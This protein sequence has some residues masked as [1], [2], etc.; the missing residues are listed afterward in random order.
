MCCFFASL[1]LLGPRLI[2]LFYWLF[3]PIKVSAAFANMALPWLVGIVGVVFAPWTTLIYVLVFP[4]NG[5]DWIW[6]GL[7]ILADVASYMGG[8]AHRQRVPGYPDKDPLPT[9]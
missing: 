2:F 7:G 1:M 3:R 8:Y 6:I 9:L 4:L 5:W